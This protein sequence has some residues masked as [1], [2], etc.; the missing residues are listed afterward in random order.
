M[1]EEALDLISTKAKLRQSKSFLW[2]VKESHI[3]ELDELLSKKWNA[4]TADNVMY[5]AK[6]ISLAF[7]EMESVQNKLDHLG[8]RLRKMGI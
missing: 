2:Q 8:S 4:K 3:R 7:E 1:N 5:H 6:Q